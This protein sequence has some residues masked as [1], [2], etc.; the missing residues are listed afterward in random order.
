MRRRFAA[1]GFVALVLATCTSCSSSSASPAQKLA[2]LD[3]NTSAVSLYQNALNALHPGCKQT[4][5]ELA[6]E[7]WF[8]SQDL[9][10]HG[11]Q[12]TGLQVLHDMR[13]SLTPVIGNG[14]DCAGILAAYLVLREGESPPSTG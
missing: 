12:E 5:E 9:G 10:K 2:T 6:A 13:N 14:I 7:A 1:I 4:D 8:G 3:N 11:I